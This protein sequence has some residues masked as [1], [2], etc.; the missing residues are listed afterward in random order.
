MAEGSG[1]AAWGRTAAILA[2]LAEVNRNP[3]ARSKPFAPHEF[4]PYE[5][6][7]KRVPD[8]KTDDITILKAL[9]PPQ[10]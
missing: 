1:R 9:L 7:K 10:R 8:F 5:F 6:G 2:M 3:K 4:N